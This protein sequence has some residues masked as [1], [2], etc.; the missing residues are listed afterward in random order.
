[1]A[2]LI[3]CRNAPKTSRTED[4]GTEFIEDGR[5]S[6]KAKGILAYMLS[7]PDDKKRLYLLELEDASVDF[8][9][10]TRSG[11]KELLKYKYI[12]RRK[13][14]W[15]DKFFY[16]WLISFKPYSQ[17]D[18]DQFLSSGFKETKVK[19]TNEEINNSFNNLKATISQDEINT[20]KRMK[21]KDF[22]NT[23]YWRTVRN[24]IAVLNNKK[25]SQCYSNKCLD[26]H[27]RTYVH[28]GE[29]I[30]YL[31]DLTLLCRVCHDKYHNEGIN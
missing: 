25:C 12:Y 14:K 22:L 27:H 24:Y 29:E 18:L 2:K 31:E 8:E 17:S 6:W 21:Y 4:I 1:M 16:D 20:L 5:L 3:I 19:F 7:L 30:F 15:D 10:S 11:I 9:I 23:P 26:C 13:H 28:R